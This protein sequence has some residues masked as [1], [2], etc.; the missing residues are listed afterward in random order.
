MCKNY[1]DTTAL[2]R[3]SGVYNRRRVVVYDYGIY[4]PCWTEQTNATAPTVFV[5]AV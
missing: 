5:F 4:E 2:Q 1:K 3:L